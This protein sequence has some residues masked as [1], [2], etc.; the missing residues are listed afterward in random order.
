MSGWTELA[1]AALPG[2]DRL[3]L[4]QRGA[5]FEIRFNLLELMSSRNPVSERALAEV[6]CARIDGAAQVLIGGLGLGYTV[7]A[8]LDRLGPGAGVTVAELV[9]AVIAWNRGP[10]ADGAGRPLED[11]RVTV[12]EGDVAALL[13]ASPGAFDAVLLDVDNG[14][15]AVLFEGNR[16]LYGPEGLAAIMKALKP[17]GLLGLWAADP[18]PGFEAVLAGQSLAFERVEVA[19]GEAGPLHTLYVVA[20]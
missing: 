18:S 4:R 14:P 2:G 10:L 16:P 13:R 19:V 11:K 3:T 15:E 17:A 6:V 7:R 12:H 1:S 9:P 8:V 20:G 5:D